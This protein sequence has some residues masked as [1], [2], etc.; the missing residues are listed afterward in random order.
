MKIRNLF[1]LAFC[2]LAFSFCS[3]KKEEK[4]IDEEKPHEHTFSD[5]VIDVEPDCEFTGVKSRKCSGCGEL[6]VVDI[7]ALGHDFTEATCMARATCK[8]CGIKEGDFAEHKYS[9]WVINEEATC[10]H[11][12]SRT[13]VC[14]WC[15]AEVSELIPSLEHNWSNWKILQNAT[16]IETGLR[17]HTCSVGNETVREVIPLIDHSFSEWEVVSNATCVKEGVS[18]HKCLYCNLEEAKSI[19]FKKHDYVLINSTKASCSHTGLN[20][21]ECSSCHIHSYKSIESNQHNF[22]DGVCAECK[23]NDADYYHILEAIDELEFNVTLMEGLILPSKVDD[24][25]VTWKSLTPTI[26]LD[27]GT[28]FASSS[29]Q[30]AVVEGT[31]TY[32]GVTFTKVFRCTI[33]VVETQGIDEC[34]SIFYSKK[35]VNSTVVNLA[36]ITK[37]YGIC[38][39]YKYTTSNPDVIT[40]KGVITQRLYSQEAVISCYLQVGK[41]IKRYDRTIEVKSYSDSQRVDLVVEWMDTVIK[42]IQDGTRTSLPITHEVYGTTINWFSMVPGVVAGNGVFVKP[43]TKQDL[44]LQCT[45]ICN[46]HSRQFTYALKNIGGGITEREQL[47]EWMKGQIPSRVWGT[48]NFVLENDALDYQIR[49]NSGGV[50]NLI[51]GENPLVDRSMLIDVNSKEW[52]NRYWGSGKYGTYHP[53]VGQ[54]ILNEMMYDGYLLPNEQN[55]LWITVHESGMPRANNDALLLAEVQHDTAIGKRTREASWNYQVDE[56]KIYQSFED[57]VICWHAGDGTNTLG[58]GNNNSIGIEMCINEDGSY[59]G[60]MYHDAK[61]IAMLLHKYNLSLANVKRHFD[62][63]G[64]ICPNYMITQGRWLEFL[65]FV[66]KEY[67]AMSLLKDKKVTWTVTTD[68]IDDTNEVLN[69]YFTKAASTIYIAKEVSVKTTLHVTMQVEYEGEIFS[70]S[71]DLVLYPEK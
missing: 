64:K 23:M 38:S 6:E 46:G 3:C 41:T 51:N 37:N 11:T 35:F 25:T 42:E 68:E 10:Q 27:D 22:V 67:T 60:A 9:D 36:F 61:L 44:E 16:C 57:E 14:E 21:Y 40:E 17:E 47:I 65:S 19:P 20:E 58:N 55:I 70:Y 63:S 34:W 1:L 43:L 33:P 50:L 56:N 13:H 24:V 48:K 31:F 66:D 62:W 12:G 2:F 28:V 45:I 52:V 15:K 53:F 54:D 18:L 39:V 5:W 32:N 4:P 26:V 69:K 30:S 59:E 7:D 71:N 49:T 29:L 8:V